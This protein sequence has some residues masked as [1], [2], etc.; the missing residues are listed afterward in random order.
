MGVGWDGRELQHL[1]P[2]ALV[3]LFFVLILSLACDY[4]LTLLACVCCL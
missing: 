4:K 2:C 1:P 3:M